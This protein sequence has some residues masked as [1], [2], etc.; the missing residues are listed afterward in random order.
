MARE[1]SS[2]MRPNRTRKPDARSR[3]IEIAVALVVA[4]V[5][6]VLTATLAGG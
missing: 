2:R 5:A 3:M 6:A 1:P 4:G